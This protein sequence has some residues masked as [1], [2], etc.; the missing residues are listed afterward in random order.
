MKIS[1]LYEN[2]NEE[3]QSCFRSNPSRAE[4]ICGLL[5]YLDSIAFIGTFVDSDR[6]YLVWWDGSYLN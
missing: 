6:T 3:L 2:L 1:K 5:N 4:F